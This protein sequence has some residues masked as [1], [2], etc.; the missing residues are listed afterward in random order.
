MKKIY[1][2][3]DL[4]V[5]HNNIRRLCNRPFAT[6]EEHDAHIIAQ[7][8][9]LPDNS[10]LYYLGDLLWGGR[11]KLFDLLD[12]F[13]KSVYWHFILGN[14]DKPLI[15]NRNEVLENF[16]N[17]HSIDYYKEIVHNGNKI[18][19]FHYPIHSF[20]GAFR[21]SYHLYGH[22]H[23][24]CKPEKLHPRARDV[25]FDTTDYTIWSIDDHLAAIDEKTPPRTRIVFSE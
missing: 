21:Y 2:T 9:S 14:H 18:C 15:T 25:G 24:N 13:K 23:G 7:V 20:N 3:A 17:V 22:S 16:N 19:L 1:A 11:D 12:T 10:T 4:H 8:N 5:G 6:A